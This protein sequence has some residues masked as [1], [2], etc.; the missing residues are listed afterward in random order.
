MDNILYGVLVGVIIW[1]ICNLI[2]KATY[3]IIT[4]IKAKKEN[5]A[6]PKDHRS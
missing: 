1:V 4:K 5:D 3:Y 2:E 6:P